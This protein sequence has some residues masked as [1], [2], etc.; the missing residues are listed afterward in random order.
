MNIMHKI[1]TFFQ[2]IVFTEASAPIAF[3]VLC[4]LNFGLLIPNLGFYM[5]DWH[6]VFY[7]KL[8]GIGSLGE[9]LTYDS[10]PGAAWFY[11][12]IFH[13]I[14]FNP[15]KWHLFNFLL[16]FSTTL[17]FWFF[18][19]SF[20]E[21]NALNNL[22]SAILFCIYPFFMLYASP[23][24][25]AHLWFGFILFNLSISF[26]VSAVETTNYKKYFFIVCALIFETTH[27]FTSEYFS[28]LE[29]IRVVILWILISRFESNFL[30]KLWRVLAHWIPYL[31]VLGFFFYWRLVIYQNPEGIFRNEPIILS[32][33]FTDPLK[34]IGL[35]VNAFFAD[36][37]SVLTVGWQQ[38]TKVSNFNLFSPFVQ[39][40]FVIGLSTFGFAYFYFKKIKI[41][42][43]QFKDNWSKSNVLLALAALMTGGLPI[44]FIGRSI[45]ESKNLISASRFGVP[46]ML[47]IALVLL[48]IVNYFVTD[49]NKKNLF[50][51]ILI[52]LALNFHLDVTKEFQTSW[53]KQER[54][55][56]QLIWRAP[57][58]KSGT[59]I[60]TDQEVLG[61]MGEYAVSFSINTAYNA[62]DFGNTPPYWYFPF[63]YTNPNIDELLNGVPLE[64]K[65]LS[66][67][68]NGSSKQMIL[69]DF[70]PQLKRCLWILQ[71]Q[72]SNLRL[73]SENVRKLAQ[74]SN[75]N[76][77]RQ[78]GEDIYPTEIYG[79]PNTKTWCYYFQKADLARQFQEWDEIVML[80]HE[81]Q[82]IGERPDNGFEY[83]PFIEGLGHTENWE[84]VKKTTKFAN[85]ISSGL[86]PSL[87]SALDRL[88]INA[89]K[90]KERDETI[91][92]LKNELNCTNY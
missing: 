92:Y 51:S 76:L 72:D 66:M 18:L 28:G 56:Q 11:I 80:W 64:Y 42:S 2:N 50:L 48:L 34:A 38:A 7:S 27:L 6:Y 78:I 54:F 59:A 46:A 23:I 15:I 44:W 43:E 58:L 73:V 77:I 31:I 3:F 24:G 88:A 36:F 40:K 13:L 91:L 74:G 10:R 75:I 69:L 37:V 20:W 21:E 57:A 12:F 39:F 35:L 52:V 22:Y 25:Y 32:L 16:V 17:S 87:C 71:P 65:K 26:M 63:L 79:K 5:D 83:I 81:A 70:N 61:I 85:K 49:K 89:P 33:L 19:K 30:K 4:V 47:G 1:K 62:K 41:D 45:A 29:L 82:S 86:E 9:M 67:V 90:S 53:E 8:K 68:F 60:L 55:I 84:Q 14:G